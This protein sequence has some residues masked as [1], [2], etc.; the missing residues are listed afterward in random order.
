M[1]QLPWWDRLGVKLAAAFALFSVLTLALFLNFVLRSQRRHLLDQAQRSAAVVSDTINSSIEHD[2]MEDRREDAYRI[3]SFIGAQAHVERLRLFDAAGRI[4]FSTTPSE[5]G[6]VPDIRAESCQPCHG[7]GKTGLPL[8]TADRTYVTTRNGRQILGAVTPIY[9]Q[10]SCSKSACHV[11]PPSQRVIGVLELGLALDAID[12]E[13][14]TLQRST[15]GLSLLLTLMLGGFTIVFTRRIVVRPLSRLAEGLNRVRAGKLDQRLPVRG[16]G[17]LAVL[18]SAFNDMDRGLSAARAERDAL[19][20]DLERQVQERTAALERAQERLIQTEKLSSLGK[21]SA[22]IAHEINNP[23]TGILTTAKLLIRTLEERPEEP[24]RERLIKHLSLVQR[25]TE[26]CSAIVRNLL[27]FARERPMTLSDADVNAALEE[28][29]FLVHNQVALQNIT[30]E[31]ALGDI[32]S[33]YADFGQLRQAFANIIINACDAMPKGGTLRVATSKVGDDAVEVRITDSGTG[34]ARELLSKVFDPFFT[35]K[36]KGTGLGLSVVY[37][38]IERHG[39][40]LTIDSTPGVGT[41]VT[42]RLPAP[43]AAAPVPAHT[44]A[45]HEGR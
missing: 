11:H 16:T 20:A 39:G 28:A 23:L 8:S 19:L 14:A 30:L 1:K 24:G 13:S 42:I 41:T 27:G 38:V 43:G 37:G 32:P 45:A 34:I 6:Q 7:A 25:E 12:R 3:M 44:G 36:E 15:I 29:L 21:L 26:R 35:T 5:V 9:N 17:E 18:E 40:K 22:S 31:R 10:P 4:H 2:M 33:V